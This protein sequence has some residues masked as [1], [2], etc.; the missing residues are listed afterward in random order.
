MIIKETLKKLEIN[1]NNIK[2]FKKL[3]NNYYIT[4][5]LFYKNNILYKIK[6]EYDDTSI[7]P[8]FDEVDIVYTLY[9]K[10]KI[11]LKKVKKDKIEKE[12]I[13]IL[14]KD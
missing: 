8:L 1:E 7:N 3:K 14:L 2:M 10:N 4:D 5:K 9:Q 11:I 12:I 6:I 13:H